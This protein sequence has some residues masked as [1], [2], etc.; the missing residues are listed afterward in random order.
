[1]HPGRVDAQ[2]LPSALVLTTGDRETLVAILDTLA[3]TFAEPGP[4]ILTERDGRWERM[5]LIP[6]E[7]VVHDHG[8][9]APELSEAGR[10]AFE[11][12]A[13]DAQI[14]TYELSWR[15]LRRLSVVPAP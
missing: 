3:P 8:P 7:W 2:T 15:A 4:R 9:I 10:R 12:G 6:C 14:L 1:M 13:I 11:M 5:L